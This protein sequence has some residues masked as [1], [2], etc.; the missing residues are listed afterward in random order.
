MKICFLSL[1]LILCCFSCNA[2]KEGNTHKDKP[3][4]S[5]LERDTIMAPYFYVKGF[6]ENDSGIYFYGLKYDSIYLYKENAEGH[7]EFNSYILLPKQ[8]TT[9]KN[10]ANI[11][12]LVFINMD[13]IIVFHETNLAL[14]STKQDRLLKIYH[15]PKYFIESWYFFIAR[16]MTFLR[17]NKER[18]TLPIMIFRHDD[19][20]KRTWRADTEILAEFSFEKDTF[21]IF[22]VKYPYYPYNFPL[23]DYYPGSDALF[24]FNGDTFV[25]SFQITPITYLY[26][27]KSGHRDSLYLQNSMYIPLPIPDTA[28]IREIS[29]L[30]FMSEAHLEHNFYTG[31]MYDEYNQVYYRFFEKYLP[32]RNA[33][34]LLNTWADKEFGL[35]VLNN[36]LQIIGDVCWSWED[37]RMATLYPTSKGLYGYYYP[38]D[39]SNLHPYGT[40]IIFKRKLIYEK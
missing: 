29:S 24:A 37:H 7:F 9:T 26:N 38:G 13:S 5:V 33:E 2:N 3:I 31:I 23:F 22:S 36:N 8:Y 20:D 10:V 1:S 28:R 17:W 11:E 21:S 12:Q 16:G 27:A 40:T 6:Y 34:G 35:T 19:D 25:F 32:R 15:R 4:S 14:F 18:Q 39:Y 30:N